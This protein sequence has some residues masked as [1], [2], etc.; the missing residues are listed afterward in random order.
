MSN[1]R[2]VLLACVPLAAATLSV[3]AAAAVPA[4]AALLDDSLA[5]QRRLLLFGMLYG[6]LLIMAVYNLLLWLTT[7]EKHYL[8]F[9][10][11]LLCVG[12][13]AGVDQGHIDQYLSLG[14]NLTHRPL[15]TLAQA[16]GIATFF[17]FSAAFLRLRRT[18]PRL[19]QWLWAL[20]LINL[21]LILAGGLF[22][23]DWTLRVEL[24]AALPLYLVA[25]LAGAR[26]RLQGVIP[27]GYY[28]V[29]V[30]VLTLGVAVGN[31][32][33][34]G[35]LP[36]GSDTG[37]TIAIATVLMAVFFSLAL[38][39]K[40][41]QLQRDSAN[42]S[43]GIAKAHIEISRINDALVKARAE[44][45]RAEQIAA[46]AHRDSRAKS[47]FL[48]RISHEIR[49][50]MNGVLGMVELLKN[51]ELEPTQ[52]HYL[53]VIERSGRGLLEVIGNLLDYAVIEAGALELENEPFNLVTLLDDCVALFTLRTLEKDIELVATVAPDVELELKGDAR[54][55]RQVIL[56]LLGNAFQLTDSGA[57]VLRVTRGE[58]PAMNC[59]ELRFEVEDTGIGLA[60]DSIEQ[61]FEPFAEGDRHGSLGLAISKQ[62]V[63]LMDGRIDVDSR[64]GHG[65]RFWFTARFMADPDAAGAERAPLQGRRL[66]LVTSPGLAADAQ[67]DTLAGWGAEVALAESGPSALAA[68][69]TGFDL[70]L[71]DHQLAGGSGLELAAE[72]RR[73]AVD[74]AAGI[75][76]GAPV[77]VLMTGL[78]K[79]PDA[80]SLE[81]SGISIVLEKPLALGPLRTS[82]TRA[83]GGRAQAANAPAAATCP[84]LRTLVVED[85]QVNQLVTAGLLRQLGIEPTLVADGLGA[86]EACQREPF[87]LILMDCEMP[88]MDGYE[89]TRRIRALEQRE[90]RPPARIIAVSAH[91][92]SDHADKAE[93]AG[94]D[95][96]LIKPVSRQDLLRAILP[97]PLADD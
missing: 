51:T 44:R 27:A 86:V 18:Q 85:N 83:L 24:V 3:A 47:D 9:V 62:L 31:F 34:L 12:Y 79:P 56:N 61:L 17:G 88:E 52:L 90:G 26:L 96:Y 19:Y 39:S 13:V 36:L 40:I 69:P 30:L 49:T 60:A 91:A 89:A 11:Y 20:A 84:A 81:R 66:L 92:T 16:G 65:S 54:K 75:A 68:L 46:S 41:D 95:A 94:M 45:D 25:L 38:A 2:R 32:T 14:L 73:Q 4:A 58:R 63:A 22:G 67:R 15:Y 37:S 87:E 35:L 50:P 5:G 82:L 7:R 48:A 59:V 71:I 77:M 53:T 74:E 1:P 42:A 29:A 64:P 10:L 8:F 55:L 21:V 6:A 23:H 43:T 57:I 78:N 72:L 97:A 93:L 76:A 80:R 33:A 70:V 28:V